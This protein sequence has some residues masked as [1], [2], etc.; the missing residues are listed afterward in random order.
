RGCNAHI[1]RLAEYQAVKK[2]DPRGVEIRKLLILRQTNNV[3][4]APHALLLAAHLL[5]VTPPFCFLL[6]AA[7]HINCHLNTL[8]IK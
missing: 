6:L 8:Y 1:V 2:I 3:C 4:V 7:W 5:L